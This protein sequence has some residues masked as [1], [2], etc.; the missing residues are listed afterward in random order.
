MLPCSM[1]D[2]RP[3]GLFTDL[4]E[5]TMAQAYLE[6]G[7]TGQAVFDLH[8]RD[9]PDDRGYMVAA[10]I[11]TLLERL[12]RFSFSDEDL[13]YLEAQGLS[14][15]LTAYLADLSFEGTVRAVP[16]G[17]LVFPYEPILQIQAPLPVAQLIETLVLN[18][19]HV[20]TLLATKAARCWQAVGGP[21]LGEEAPALVDFGAR[22]AHGT[23]AAR[24]AARC[25]Y[26]GGFAGTSLVEVGRDLDIP[27]FGTMAHS[28][29]QSFQ[30]ERQALEAFAR[31][32][33]GTT[34]LIDTYDTIEGARL[35]VDIADQLAEEG[36]EVGAVRLDSGD[37]AELS[38]E[39]RA[40][41]DDGGYEDIDIIASGGLD[42]FELAELTQ[43]QAPIDGYG[44]GTSLVVSDDHPSLNISYK[45]CEYEGQPVMKTSPKK[46]TLPGRKQVHRRSDDEGDLLGDTIA[47]VDE[48]VEGPGLLEPVERVVPAKAV[49]AARER[50]LE[51]HPRL[52]A[53]YRDNRDPAPYP[54]DRSAG[55]EAA[56]DRALRRVGRLP[57]SDLSGQTR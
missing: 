10:G 48:D 17:R 4:Y 38:K 41:L 46:H 2:L 55:I 52:P 12:E 50:F 13:A 16:E 28:F 35:A 9:L 42:E 29:I 47:L 45:L 37:L 15:E 49:E 31:T 43:A 39:V 22:R 18:T 34:L 57:G 6:H 1:A 33:P 8:V 3:S 7:M 19:I 40:I 54:V 21:E 32:F 36:I 23:D 11:N 20:E 14:E 51:E 44:V 53:A 56:I 5:F 24:T 30:E 27:I 26:L 25:A